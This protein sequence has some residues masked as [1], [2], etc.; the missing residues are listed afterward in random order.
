[1]EKVWSEW[2][3]DQGKLSTLGI[4]GDVGH[5][6]PE[7]APEETAAAILEFYQKHVST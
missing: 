4:T 1:M 7:E 2:V 5:F 6:L 3:S